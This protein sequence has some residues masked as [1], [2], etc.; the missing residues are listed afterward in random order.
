MMDL[1]PQQAV[2]KPLRL[3]PD[4]CMPKWSFANPL[5]N[6]FLDTVFQDEDNRPDLFEDAFPRQMGN[7]IHAVLRSNKVYWVPG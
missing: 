2:L 3:K 7:L 1:L 5:Q 6:Y 4:W